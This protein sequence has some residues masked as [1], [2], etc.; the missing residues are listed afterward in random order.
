M[1]E[2]KTER[3]NCRFTVQ[4]SDPEINQSSSLLCP[5]ME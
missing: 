5:A 1:A 2:T 3:S 4:Q